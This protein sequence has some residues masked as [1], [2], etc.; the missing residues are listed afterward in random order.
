MT[1]RISTMLRRKQT[2]AQL[3]EFALVF[4]LMILIILLGIDASLFAYNKA[5][6]TNASREFARQAIV[7][8]STPW[9]ATQIAQAACASISTAL[10]SFSNATSTP[11]CT[12][13][14]TLGSSTTLTS[15]PTFGDQVTVE[16]SYVPT[17][18]FWTAYQGFTRAVTESGPFALSAATSMMHE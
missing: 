18:L 3:I 5:V 9:D 1:A 14:A 10:V 13:T 7:L 17:G 6:M 11:Q 8:G 2:G 4:P 12:V 15:T 16:I